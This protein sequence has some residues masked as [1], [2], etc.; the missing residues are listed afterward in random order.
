M[1]ALKFKKVGNVGFFCETL[2]ARY[3][4]K[5]NDNCTVT[6]EAIMTGYGK[7]WIICF[8]GTDEKFIC[9]NGF[10]DPTNTKKEAVECANDLVNYLNSK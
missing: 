9:E 3:E 2:S 6:I 4:A 7:S 5:V 8:N 10:I 1:E